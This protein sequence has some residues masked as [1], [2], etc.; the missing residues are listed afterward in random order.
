MTDIIFRFDK[1][2]KKKVEM[3]KRL[4]KSGR[5]LLGQVRVNEGVN[6]NGR[7]RR[8]P[9]EPT[10]KYSLRYN[11]RFDYDVDDAENCEYLK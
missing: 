2:I 4:A 10:A 9:K 8:G 7:A 1:N 3:G 6:Q 11:T 5:P